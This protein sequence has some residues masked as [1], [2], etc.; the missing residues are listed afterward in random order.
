M[1]KMSQAS[2]LV[3]FLAQDYRCLFCRRIADGGPRQ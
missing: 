1:F 2:K 3:R